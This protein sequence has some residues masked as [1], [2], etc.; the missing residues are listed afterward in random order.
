MADKPD[1]VDQGALVAAEHGVQRSKLWPSL[2][3]WM[4]KFFNNACQLCGQGPV[5]IHHWIPFHDCVLCGRP[6]L[7]LSFDNLTAL[8]ENE[9]DKPTQDHHLIAGH[10][11]DFRSYNKILKDCIPQWKGLPGTAIKEMD[12]WKK[13]EAARPLSYPKMDPEAQAQ[14]CADVDKLLP[15]DQV[16]V[17]DGKKFMK[18]GV[19]FTPAK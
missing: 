19:V 12:M 11:C 18:N 14:F 1:K 15:K 3:R 2:E 10:L 5:Q 9:K 7:E 6:E 4:K 13:L 17:W 16:A 8:C